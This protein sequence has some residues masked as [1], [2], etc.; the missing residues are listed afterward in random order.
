MHPKGTGTTIPDTEVKI[1]TEAATRIATTDATEN[2]TTA[3]HRMGSSVAETI[4]RPRAGPMTTETGAG[5][6]H[7][8]K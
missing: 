6:I 1:H 3:H 2:S 8:G 7:P 4:V 5:T